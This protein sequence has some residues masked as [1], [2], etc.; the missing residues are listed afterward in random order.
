MNT[1]S[2]LELNQ[3]NYNNKYGSGW[4]TNN[5]NDNVPKVLYPTGDATLTSGRKYVALPAK[6]IITQ[7]IREKYNII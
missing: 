7:E 6:T 3:M 4:I 2:Y 5:T 1:Y